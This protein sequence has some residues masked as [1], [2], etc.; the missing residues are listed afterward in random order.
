ML[1]FALA[2][3]V[4]AI[5]ALVVSY[6]LVFA[7]V[8]N[9]A[10]ADPPDTEYSER[11]GLLEAM[12]ELELSFQTGKLS[13]EDYQAQKARLQRQYLRLAGSAGTSARS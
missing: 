2:A 9:Y 4:L 1:L 6:P 7:P 5:A 11:D 12:S 8:E 3:V 10:V 13:Q